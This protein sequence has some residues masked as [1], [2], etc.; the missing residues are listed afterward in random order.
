MDKVLY[1]PRDCSVLFA[2]DD[3]LFREATEQLLRYLFRDVHVARDGGE[4]LTLYRQVRPDILLLDLLFAPFTQA[5]GSITRRFGGTGLGLSISQRLVGL[6]GG[7]ISVTSAQ[8][9][10]SEFSFQIR[11]AVAEAGGE[12]PRPRVKATPLA[13]PDDPGST[14]PPGR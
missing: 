3:P 14:H 10:G 4:A 5:D 8:G 12:P 11:L 9:Q 6:M 2:D 7:E 13:V 1:K